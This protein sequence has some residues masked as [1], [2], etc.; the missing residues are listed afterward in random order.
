MFSHNFPI[1]K[2]FQKQFGWQHFHPILYGIILDNIHDSILTTIETKTTFILHK[3]INL[4][5]K[6][7][8]KNLLIIAIMLITFCTYAQK[9]DLIGH[10]KLTYVKDPI[11]N[12]ADTM[13]ENVD[14]LSIMF[15]GNHTYKCFLSVNTVM[16]TYMTDGGFSIKSGSSTKIC[17]DDEKSL[18]FYDLLLGAKGY[19][20]KFGSLKIFTMNYELNF[21]KL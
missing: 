9:K 13:F 16:G 4:K 8:K 5:I 20:F 12:V 19:M 6:Y 17:C 1:S 2:F 18:K 10:W 3:I 14:Y 21:E 11:T 15:T 7:M